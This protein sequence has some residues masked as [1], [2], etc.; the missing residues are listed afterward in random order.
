MVETINYTDAVRTFANY[1]VSKYSKDLSQI[2]ARSFSNGFFRNEINL[3]MFKFLAEKINVHNLELKNFLIWT[4]SLYNDYSSDGENFSNI[5]LNKE[6][7]S[8]I[9]LLQHIIDFK[10]SIA[11]CDPLDSTQKDQLTLIHYKFMSKF[12]NNGNHI[13]TFLGNHVDSHLNAR[14][15]QSASFNNNVS[16]NS[17]SSQN[18]LLN[19][20]NSNKKDFKFIRKKLNKMLRYENHIEIFKIHKG[21]KTTPKSLFFE[22]FPRPFFPDDVEFVEKHNNLILNFQNESMTMITE[23]LEKRVS[24]VIDDINEFKT[25]FEEMPKYSE[26]KNNFDE[27]KKIIYE[28]E[29]NQ[30]LDMFVRNKQRAERC[31]VQKFQVQNFDGNSTNNSNTTNS[32]NT[33][34]GSNNSSIN[35]SN[36]RKRKSVNWPRNDVQNNMGNDN[37]YNNNFRNNNM[38]NDNSSNNHNNNYRSN[39]RQNSYN[40]T[41]NTQN[42]NF[43]NNNNRFNDNNNRNN[44]NNGNNYFSNNNNRSD[45]TN[46]NFNY[47]N[48]SNFNGQNR[49][50]NQNNSG[51]QNRHHSNR[52]N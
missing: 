30:M 38:N 31:T 39:F 43:N 10:G 41:N 34:N 9:N 23:T 27:L 19:V 47:T 32:S 48:N 8:I 20:I 6:N 35:S 15:D 29:E 4:L 13:E 40:G 46:G 12:S 44:R 45:N 16:S 33:T 28:T 21:R 1:F 5:H 7:N 22:N 18:R 14:N 36:H 17:N 51:F 26:F 42:N 3:K 24:N 49:Q 11:D 2:N 37:R 25:E 50:N 52:F